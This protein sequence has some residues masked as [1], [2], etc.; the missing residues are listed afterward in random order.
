MFQ[1]MLLL[2]QTMTET[3]MAEQ[4]FN[5]EAMVLPQNAEAAVMGLGVAFVMIYLIMMVVW[6]V[7]MVAVVLVPL[8]LICK[9]AGISPYISL[10]ILVPGANLAIYWI[11]A[12]VNWPNLKP[13]AEQNANHF[14]T[15]N[16]SPTNPE[17]DM[18]SSN[19]LD[20]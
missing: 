13:E 4:F 15:Q 10:L 20:G 19:K 3:E 18:E 12:L 1:K 9:K 6:L 5:N 8:W 2:A 16:P 17:Q 14:V 11:L 7:I